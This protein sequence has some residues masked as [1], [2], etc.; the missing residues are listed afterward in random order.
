MVPRGELSCR[1]P[2]KAVLH[3]YV[4]KNRLGF[5]CEQCARHSP[6]LRAFLVAAG[7]FYEWRYLSFSYSHA[8]VTNP[9]FRVYLE[10]VIG[11]EGERAAFRRED[12]LKARIAWAGGIPASVAT[13]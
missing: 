6:T 9:S 8:A 7:W 1:C 5:I 11:Q 12:A 10:K 13:G 2:A 3:V 4:G